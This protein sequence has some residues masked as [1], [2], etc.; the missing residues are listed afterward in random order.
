MLTV[1]MHPTERRKQ[2]QL[3]ATHRND[4]EMNGEE[5]RNAKIVSHRGRHYQTGKC[6]QPKGMNE[7]AHHHNSLKYSTKK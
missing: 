1:V 7:A 2:S 4:E 3:N 6:N 5:R